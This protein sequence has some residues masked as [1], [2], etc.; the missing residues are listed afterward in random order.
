MNCDARG[1]RERDEVEEKTKHLPYYDKFIDI[2]FKKK[3]FFIF[4][5]ALATMH[6]CLDLS[7]VR[8]RER[9]KTISGNFEFLTMCHRHSAV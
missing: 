3:V 1:R 2:S 8:E 6:R 9:K 5:N 7:R 4:S